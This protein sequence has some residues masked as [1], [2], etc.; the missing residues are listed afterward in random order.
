VHV[1]FFRQNRLVCPITNSLFLRNVANDTTSVLKKELLNLCYSIKSCAISGSPCVFVIGNR[2]AT[3]L[4]PGMLLKH[5]YMTHVLVPES[6]LYHYE[7]LR[8]TFPKIGTKFDAHS[9]FF[10][11]IHR[12]NLHGSRTRLQ[13]NACGNCPRPPSYVQLGTLTH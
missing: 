12:A 11:L 5:L 2:C 6:L 10:S 7:C 9:L 1:Q 13:T 3:G 4:E 8:S